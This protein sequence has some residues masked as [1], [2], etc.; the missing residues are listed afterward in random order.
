MAERNSGAGMDTTKE[1]AGVGASSAGVQ[2]SV[3]ISSQVQCRSSPTCRISSAGQRIITTG[4]AETTSHPLEI[5]LSSTG[6]RMGP[7]ITLDLWKNVM[8]EPFTP[9]RATEVMR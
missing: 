7:V 1:S 8:E 2:I 5:S 9:L 4:R 3:G 6:T